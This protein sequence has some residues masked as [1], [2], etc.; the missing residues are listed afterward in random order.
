MLM[1]ISM[2]FLSR[3][4]DRN[5]VVITS[6]SL[7]F[8]GAVHSMQGISSDKQIF[9]VN[10]PFQNKM[11]S[12]LLP[13][14]LKG[15]PMKIKEIK[16][17]LPFKLLE[18]SPQL[19]SEVQFMSKTVFRLKVEGPAVNYEGPMSVTI[20]DEPEETI[21][22]NI[23]AI[24][25]RKG[26]ERAELQNSSMRLSLQKGQIFKTELQM[27]NILKYNDKISKVRAALPFIV[28]STDPAAPTAVD[29]KDSY[30]M[31]IYVRAPDSN[32]T[33]DLEIIV[34]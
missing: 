24:V 29:R 34:E 12:N 16:V 27:Y 7:R 28:E 13:G 14:N 26:S 17:S 11:G 18:S 22:L 21:G 33:G 10:I 25:L 19:P 2:P 30:V 1:K 3:K 9:Y 15:P 6:I 31:K 5:K 23:K 4:K 8:M 32:Y 20:N